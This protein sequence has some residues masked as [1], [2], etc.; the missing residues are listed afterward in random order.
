MLIYKFHPRL[1]KKYTPNLKGYILLVLTFPGHGLLKRTKYSFFFKIFFLHVQKGSGSE[2]FKMEDF[3]RKKFLWK[4]ITLYIHIY[5]FLDNKLLI[6]TVSKS[7]FAYSCV[8][9][10]SGIKHFLYI[11][12]IKKVLSVYT[13]SFNDDYIH[14][15]PWAP[16]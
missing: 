10:H 8:L 16:R 11:Q 2:W 12:L 9:R 1:S 15:Y 3:K 13:R 4:I 6:C 7:F 14:I 5:F